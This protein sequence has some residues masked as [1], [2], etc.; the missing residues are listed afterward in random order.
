MEIKELENLFE[1]LLGCVEGL[2][3]EIMNII[4]CEQLS[5]EWFAARLGHVTGSHFADVLNKATGRKTYMYKVMAEILSGEV[6]PSYSNKAME[7][8]SEYESD[9]REYYEAL[10]G[11]IQQVGFVERDEYVGCSPD[12]LVGKDGIIEIKYPFPSTHLAYIIKNKLPATYVPQ[13]Q[14]NL[15]VTDRKW[16]DFV[17]FNAK[18]KDRPF[19]CVRIE[20][21]EKYINVLSEGVK[22]FVEDLKELISQIKTNEMPY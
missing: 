13:V 22:V 19:W 12:G 10:F 20:R 17:S 2:K 5:D 14:G 9:A 7:F 4:D 3:G 18:I 21:E 8:G 16:C 15:W 1:F 11:K 6:A